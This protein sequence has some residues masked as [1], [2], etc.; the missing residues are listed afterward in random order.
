MPV[1]VKEPLFIRVEATDELRVEVLLSAVL[2]VRAQPSLIVRAA[3]SVG[4]ITTLSK[5]SVGLPVTVAMTS[6]LV[7]GDAPSTILTVPLKRVDVPLSPCLELHL[8]SE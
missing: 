7:D 6:L 5:V 2:M 1:S 8:P 3:P 4:L